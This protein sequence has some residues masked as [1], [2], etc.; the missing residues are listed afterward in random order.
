VSTR[1]LTGSAAQNGTPLRQNIDAGHVKSHG[2]SYVKELAQRNCTDACTVHGVLEKNENI[3]KTSEK[4]ACELKRDFVR[5][6][7]FKSPAG[8]C[9]RYIV[10]SRIW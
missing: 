9:W 5:T 3:L 4:C 2:P 7:T 8:C 1:L 10:L 6:S